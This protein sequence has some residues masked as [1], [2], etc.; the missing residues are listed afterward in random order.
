MEA[1]TPL[2]KPVTVKFTAPMK[3][4]W[5]DTVMVSETDAPWASVGV[6]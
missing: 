2:G 4:A 1:V 6:G 5:G 3:P